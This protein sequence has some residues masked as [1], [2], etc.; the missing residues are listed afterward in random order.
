MK[1]L[2][3]DDSKVMRTLVRRALRQAG[4]GSN[5]LLEAGNGCEA[6]EVIDCENPD[7]VLSDWNMPEM[8]GLELLTKIREDGCRVPFVFV[9]TEGTQ[10]MRDTAAEAGASSFLVK[11][12]T[13][14]DVSAALDPLVG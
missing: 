11:P 4:Y 10:K 8:N 6:I 2:I 1:I 12:F 5:T 14:D 13:S 3:V 9:T 7:I